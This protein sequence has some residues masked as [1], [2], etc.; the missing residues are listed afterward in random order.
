ML[1]FNYSPKLKH[2]GNEVLA[3]ALQADAVVLVK[4]SA[5]STPFGW[6]K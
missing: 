5:G 1:K 6:Y 4:N 3:Q 2:N